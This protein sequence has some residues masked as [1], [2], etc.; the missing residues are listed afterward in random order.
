M[1]NKNSFIKLIHM[2]A[3]VRETHP[4]LM[5]ITPQH[6]SFKTRINPK[7]ATTIRYLICK[8]STFLGQKVIPALPNTTVL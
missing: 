4:C 1:P 5:Q 6:D 8:H 7:L 3:S 2:T